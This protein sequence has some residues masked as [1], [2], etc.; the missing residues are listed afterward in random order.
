MQ[1]NVLISIYGN[2]AMTEDGEPENITFVTRGV[3]EE[4]NGVQTLRY[5]ESDEES[6]ESYGTNIVVEGERVSV[7]DEYNLTHLMFQKGLRF[8][9]VF[10]DGEDGM[11]ELGVFPTRVDI[12]MGEESGSIDLSY[13][14]DIDGDVIGD[15][16]ITV[17]Y[18]SVN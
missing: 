6:G 5:H 11:Y 4:G 1:K 17:S 3:Y 18:R 7:I 9:S 2:S 10:A 8:S 13:Q 15:N 14:M 12:S 16:S